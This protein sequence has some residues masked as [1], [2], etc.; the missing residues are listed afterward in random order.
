MGFNGLE[1]L[2][3]QVFSEVTI[4]RLLLEHARHQLFGVVA[5]VIGLVWNL[6]LGLFIFL[7]TVPAL[8]VDPVM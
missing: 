7:V 6:P 1:I 4:W 5:H 8:F 2:A 3:I